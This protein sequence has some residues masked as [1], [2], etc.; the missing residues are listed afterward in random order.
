MLTNIFGNNVRSGTVSVN[1][2]YIFLITKTFYAL[3]DQETAQKY[4]F[5]LC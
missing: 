3:Q 1:E 2:I 5:I 4:Q